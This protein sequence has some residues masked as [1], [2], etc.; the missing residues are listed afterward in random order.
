MDETTT[1]LPLSPCLMLS[2]DTEE[3]G[4]SGGRSLHFIIS[5]NAPV[6]QLSRLSTT[7][8]TIT[9]EKAHLGDDDMEI[10]VIK[11]TESIQ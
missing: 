8:T 2:E 1:M 5:T 4:H 3:Q 6:I 7:T 9:I 11:L 10:D